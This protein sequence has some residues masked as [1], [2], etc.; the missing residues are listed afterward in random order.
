[1][2]ELMKF[3][4]IDAHM[5]TTFY[6]RKYLEIAKTY[7][8]RFITINTDASVF[9]SI[10]IQEKVAQDYMQK[11]KDY[12]S[13]IAS[14]PMD[15][16]TRPDW[17]HKT[18]DQIKRS[19]QNGAVGIKLWKN[20]GMEILKEDKSYLL[21]DDPFFDQLF[22]FLDEAQ[23]PVLAHLGEPKNCWLPLDRM[24][25]KRNRQYYEKHPEFH[26]YLHP[27]IPSYERQIEARNQILKRYPNLDF[28]GAHLGSMEWN[29]KVLSDCF[30]HFPNF[31]VDFSSRLGH[32]QLQSLKDHEGVRD[33]FIKYAD[34]IMYGSDAYDNI[35]KLLASLN[36]DWDFLATYNRCQT[37]EIDGSFRGLCLPEEV[38]YKIYYENALKTYAN[39]DLLE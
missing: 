36:N 9:P 38:L 1:M 10:D 32:L 18:M 29:Y 37:T 8:V 19:V 4:K 31:K 25:S 24:T 3:P 12:F 20:I 13:Y 39:L 16:W 5:H 34:R 23:I 7:N 22:R 17:Y 6:A 26:A 27:Y 21:I 30:D 33:F 2:L 28:V 15:G 14:F 35:E 11:H